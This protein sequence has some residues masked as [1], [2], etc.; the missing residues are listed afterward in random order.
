M[1]PG[2]LFLAYG[3]IVIVAMYVFVYIPNK[4]KHRKMQEMH[5]SIAAGDM[6]ITIGGVVGRVV[7]KEKKEGDY[8]TLVIDEE[9]EVTM[10]IVL[11]AVNQKIDK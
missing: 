8:L 3:V 5:N 10:R 9:K 2:L 11:Y 7:K 4:K 1:S 6:V